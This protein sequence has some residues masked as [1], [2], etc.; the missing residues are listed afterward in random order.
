M[1]FKRLAASIVF[2]VSLL[3]VKAETHTVVF[4]KRLGMSIC[5]GKVYSSFL[6]SPDVALERQA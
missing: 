6:F 2:A 1:F 3:Q 4:D 5:F